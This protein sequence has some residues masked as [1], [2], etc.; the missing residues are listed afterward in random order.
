[1]TQCYNN[2]YVMWPN[3]IIMTAKWPNVII[4]TIMQPNVIIMTNVTQCYNNDCVMQPNVIIM[5]TW[6]KD[7]IQWHKNTCPCLNL[8]FTFMRAL[9]VHFLHALW[10][11]V[12]LNA[13]IS[14][15]LIELNVK[16]SWLVY[17]TFFMELSQIPLW[18]SFTGS[19]THPSMMFLFWYIYFIV[20]LCH[21]L[22]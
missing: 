15:D 12:Y 19:I 7:T 22:L 2:D 6:I 21:H 8:S 3:V 20:I 4:M 17:F 9:L 1:M 11:L 5:T 16:S 10:T 13:D 14:H 18:H